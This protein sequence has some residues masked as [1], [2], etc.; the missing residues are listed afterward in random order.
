MGGERIGD[1]GGGREFERVSNELR[2]RIVVGRYA[3]RS[4]LPTQRELAD[5]FGVSRD[6]VQRALAKLRDE[7]LIESRQGSG[8]RVVST[9]EQQPGPAGEPPPDAT[10]PA[11]RS[12]STVSSRISE[13]FQQPEVTLDVFTLTSESLDSSITLQGERIRT[14]EIAP[15]RIALRML[16]PAEDLPLPYLRAL[17]DPK[18]VRPLERLRK[19]AHDSTT[20]L[21]RKLEELRAQ[22][23]VPQVD[24][25]I[26]YVA[27][28]PPFKLYLLNGREALFGMYEVIQRPIVLP[29]MEE[30]DAIDV[31][32]L[33][34]RLLHFEKSEDP[35]FYGTAFVDRMQSWFDSVW[36][37]IA[38]DA[39]G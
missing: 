24:V 2:S 10:A 20:S 19:I 27:I 25:S 39:Q 16:I 22:G 15:Q 26:R 18:D 32:G 4:L 3:P 8:S 7:G 37:L 36:G 14:G 30:I 33:G 23:H 11:R 31:D 1:E 5:Q 29:T 21:R 9:G 6:T 35:D 17:A 28:P 38:I 12:H 34:A 13:A